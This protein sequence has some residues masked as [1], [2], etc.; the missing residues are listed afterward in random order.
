M[1]NESGKKIV[2]PATVWGDKVGGAAFTLIRDYVR[3][4]LKLPETDTVT[5]VF[6]GE[7]DQWNTPSSIV[8]NPVTKDW[9]GGFRTKAAA[10]I[11][12]KNVA[13]V[14]SGLGTGKTHEPGESNAPVSSGKGSHGFKATAEFDLEHGT[15]NICLGDGGCLDFD[16][17]SS[18]VGINTAVLSVYTKKIAD[19]ATNPRKFLDMC[20]E[21]VGGNLVQAGFAY[22]EYSSNKTDITQAAM[23]IGQQAM[24]KMD[25]AVMGDI[26]KIIQNPAEHLKNTGSGVK[27]AWLEKWM[28][29][30]EPP[31]PAPSVPGETPVNLVPGYVAGTVKDLVPSGV[32][33]NPVET[34]PEQPEQPVPDKAVKRGGRIVR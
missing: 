17:E 9:N 3:N 2:V 26:V 18:H 28:P 13:D 11:K 8:W 29:V 10:A 14:K 7:T 4:D 19:F 31:A 1:S 27:M 20:G 5:R 21:T 23:E 32:P 24:A 33:T 6:Y 30:V 15:C 12:G 16:A 34:S 22:G 25:F